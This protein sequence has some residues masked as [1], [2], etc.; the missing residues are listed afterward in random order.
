MLVRHEHW[1]DNTVTEAMKQEWAAARQD[2]PDPDL[3]P[4]ARP[5]D[6]ELSRKAIEEYNAEQVREADEREQARQDEGEEWPAP[7][8]I[9]GFDE[10][11]FEHSWEMQEWERREM[12]H[13]EKRRLAR[14]EPGS[15]IGRCRPN[16]GAS[17]PS[18]H[19]T[20]A[21]R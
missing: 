11:L 9:V 19:A 2:D 15:W 10:W 13:R 18:W 5:I 16:H 7:H 14:R 8:R 1:Q 17:G 3:G 4:R 20:C 21:P 6:E 12:E